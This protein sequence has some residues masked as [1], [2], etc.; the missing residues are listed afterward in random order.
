MLASGEIEKAVALFSRAY[1]LCK[2]DMDLL[3]NYAEALRLLGRNKE[4][5]ELL[6][7]AEG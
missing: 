2:T 5:E 3:S 4:A 1:R 6:K 7:R